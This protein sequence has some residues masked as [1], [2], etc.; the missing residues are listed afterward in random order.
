MGRDLMVYWV[1]KELRDSKVRTDG[2]LSYAGSDQFKKMSV[3]SGDTL[4][5][6][7]IPD[8]GE[9]DAGKLNLLGR[10]IVGS[11]LTLEQAIAVRGAH[12]VRGD[13]K[14]HVEAKTGTEMSY[15]NI[16][17]AHIARDLRFESKTN[18]RLTVA[19]EGF[20]RGEQIQSI[21]IL[22]PESVARLRRAMEEYREG[23][24]KAMERLIK[25][26]HDEDE[27]E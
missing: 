1:W 20:V 22:A 21:R 16:P 14:Y 26:H 13:R 2:T 12:R 18:D 17:L 9:P 8:D 5:L 4:W 24:L 11:T 23:R 7:T 10:L 25:R 19:G 27:G 15:Q 6:V 3:R